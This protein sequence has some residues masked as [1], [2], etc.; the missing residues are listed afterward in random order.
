M[1]ENVTRDDVGLREGLRE[2]AGE[3]R[4]DVSRENIESKLQ[5]VVN[6]RP[7]AKYL[8]DMGIVLRAL[9]V[10]AI[11]CL[12]LV[13]ISPKAAA[14]FLVVGFLAAWAILAVREYNRRRPTTP[15]DGDDKDDEDE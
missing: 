15:A 11:I 14:F 12:I 10:A 1:A 6:E 13:W 4:E 9:L 8:L 3:L 5:D 7:V 2:G